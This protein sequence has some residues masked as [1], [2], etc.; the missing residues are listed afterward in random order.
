MTHPP[1]RTL[2]LQDPNGQTMTEYGLLLALIFS[3][4]LVTLTVYGGWLS[5][6][7]GSVNNSI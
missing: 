6:L 3:V 4:V 2:D 1:R 7:W 5:G